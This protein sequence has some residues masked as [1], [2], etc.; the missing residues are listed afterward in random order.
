MSKIFDEEYVDCVDCEIYWTNRCDG[1]PDATERPCTAF[2]AIRSINV[3]QQIKA[4]KTQIKWLVRL[5]VFLIVMVAAVTV[6]L[7]C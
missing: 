6:Y 3:P 7:M 5:I 2:I 4:L 1:V